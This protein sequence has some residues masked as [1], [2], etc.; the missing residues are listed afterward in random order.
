MYKDFLGAKEEWMSKSGEEPKNF[1]NY[2][3]VP[4]KKDFRSNSVCSESL[5]DLELLAQVSKINDKGY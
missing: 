1:K 3:V 4:L 2:F 5:L